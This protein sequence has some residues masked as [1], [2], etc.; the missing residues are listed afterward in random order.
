MSVWFLF[1]VYNMCLPVSQNIASPSNFTPWMWP[2]AQPSFQI[3]ALAKRQQSSK[4][5]TSIPST[6]Y[7]GNQQLPPHTSQSMH[8][9]SNQIGNHAL[10]FPPHTASCPTNATSFQTP[11]PTKTQQCFILNTTQTKPSESLSVADAIC[12]TAQRLGFCGRW[13]N[14]EIT[15]YKYRGPFLTI[16]PPDLVFYTRNRILNLIQTR[17]PSWLGQ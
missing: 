2:A 10:T 4:Q 1:S 6:S 17:V 12:T 16:C 11:A 5:C 13:R 15:L 9:Q 8:A 7:Q 14:G 3:S